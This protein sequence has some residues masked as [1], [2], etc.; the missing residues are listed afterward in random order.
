MANSWPAVSGTTTGYT[1]SGVTTI[2]WGTDGVLQSP[3]PGSGFYVV[4]RATQRALVDNIKLPNGTGPTI[5]RVLIKDGAVWDLT[6][7]DDSQM[8]P[9]Q[10]SGPTVGKSVTIT[11]MAGMITGSVAPNT[12]GRTFKIGRAHV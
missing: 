4:L 1:A 12:P 10:S 3:K 6:V 7:R 9:S 11:D 2:R 8:D 5:T